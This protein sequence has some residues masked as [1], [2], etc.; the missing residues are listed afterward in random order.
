MVVCE[1]AKSIAPFLAPHRFDL[2]STF[3][4]PDCFGM[5]V[6]VAKMAFFPGWQ[7]SYKQQQ[8]TQQPLASDIYAWKKFTHK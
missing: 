2:L 5:V 4:C 7:Y 3:F 8:E 6:E 1:L